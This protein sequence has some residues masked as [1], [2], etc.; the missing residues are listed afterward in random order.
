MGPTPTTVVRAH[1]PA[2]AGL[3]LWQTPMKGAFIVSYDQIVSVPFM[4]LNIFG[5]RCA[6]YQF[7]HVRSAFF[8]P[9]IRQ[10]G[11]H[12]RDFPKRAVCI[13]H[14]VARP[15]DYERVINRQ[16][17]VAVPVDI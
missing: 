1:D 12:R 11:C 5:P 17:F 2:E 10:H 8:R 16:G 9:V 7:L 15:V 6:R 4:G 13:P 3:L 14:L